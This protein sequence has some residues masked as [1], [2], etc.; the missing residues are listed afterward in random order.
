[1]FHLTA[2]QG[3]KMHKF[4][5]IAHLP[6]RAAFVLVRHL[7]PWGSGLVSIVTLVLTTVIGEILIQAADMFLGGHQVTYQGR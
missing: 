5:N 6:M 4:D 3:V 2:A 7:G 1:M